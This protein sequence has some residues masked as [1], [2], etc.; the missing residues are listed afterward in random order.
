MS[1]IFKVVRLNFIPSKDDIC[2]TRTLIDNFPIFTKIDPLKYLM[3]YLKSCQ[4]DGI[5]PLV[6]PFSPPE[7][8][9]DVHGKRKKDYRGDGFS[10]S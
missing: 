9:P 5:D 7:T 8:Y 3:A 4:K 2:R 1:L 10:R 6:D